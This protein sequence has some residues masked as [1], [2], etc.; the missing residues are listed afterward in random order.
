MTTRIAIIAR[1]Q[2]QVTAAFYYDVPTKR[3]VKMGFVSAFATLAPADLA[4]LQSGA[5]IEQVRVINYSGWSIAQARADL[6]LQ[7]ATG[8]A[9]AVADNDRTFDA[10]GRTWDGLVWS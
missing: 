5:L 10:V 2:D 4:L 7:W 9:E 8:L 3:V 1:S 6:Q